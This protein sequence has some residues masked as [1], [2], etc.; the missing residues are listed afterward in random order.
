MANQPALVAHYHE[1]GLKGRNRNFFE[2]ALDRNLRRALRGTG[3]RKI[4]N[5][6]GR[7]VID[8]EPDG[9]VAEAA[10]RAARVFGVVYLGV[11]H[12]VEPDL[13]AIGDAAVELAKAEP[14]DSFAVRAR[15]TY[16]NF[17]TKSQQINETVGQRIVDATAG[18]VD[19]KNPDATIWI[20]LFAKTG[21]IYRTRLQGPG[22]LPVGTSGRMLALLSGGID[23][24]VAAWRMARRGADVEFIHFHGRPYTDPSSIRQAT[25]LVEALTRYQLKSTLHLVP[26]GDVQ[27]DIV[28]SAPANMR[29]I[30]YRRAMMRIAERLADERRA[31]ALITGDSLGQVAS[32]TIENI[33]TVNGAI[34]DIEVFRPLIGMDKQEIVDQAT[35]ICTYEISTRPHQDCCV[36]FEAREPA[37]RANVGIAEKAESELDIDALTARALEG[38]ETQE[39]ELPDP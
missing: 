23:S 10:R 25:E 5:R 26:L 7:V 36:L 39:F 12:R 8:M 34:K 13:D 33:R 2:D 17:N 6:F 31:V 22:G 32:Q 20:E 15:R 4:R 38:V 18:K 37:T 35:A 29:I 14:F 30:L 19:L 27:R 16:S 3:Y 21:V 28:M 9:N 1:I 24:P 11:G